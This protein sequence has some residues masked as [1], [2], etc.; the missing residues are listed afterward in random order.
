MDAL[1]LIRLRNDFYRDN[2]RRLIVILLML[3]VLMFG[4]A[5]WIYYLT[6]H[7][8]QPRY[9]ATNAIGGLAPLRALNQPSMSQGQLQNW[10]A[11]AA[12]TTFTFNFAQLTQQLAYARETY[13]TD[14]GGTAFMKAL[15]ASKDLDA[16]VQG[17]F[18]VISQ[19]TGAPQILSQGVMQSGNYKGR[20]A[21]VVKV[22]LQIAYQSAAMNVSS[23][24]D[25][26]VQMTIVR[27]SPLVDNAA[28]NIDG[29]QGVGVSQLLVKGLSGGT[30][31]GF[32]PLHGQA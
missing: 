17:K 12:A 18:I 2:Y 26:D 19:P 10:A 24:R 13:F 25:V 4:L 28:P 20:Y 3:M 5:Y 23:R 21:W 8:P 30:G 14:A 11:R 15:T 16:V 22:P 29:L 9:F 6:T 7:R 32:N 27:T 31:G 1:E